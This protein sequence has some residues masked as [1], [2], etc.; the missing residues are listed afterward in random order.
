MGIFSRTAQEITAKSS[1]IAGQGFELHPANAVNYSTEPQAVKMA[2]GK[3]VGRSEP[4]PD[5]QHIIAL[6]NTLSTEIKQV[7]L[8]LVKFQIK[9]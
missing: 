6:W 2:V 4:P 3:T 7:I 9:Q 1:S 5:L 8:T